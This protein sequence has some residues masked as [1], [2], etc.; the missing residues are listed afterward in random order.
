MASANWMKAT[1]QKAGAMKK[2]LGQQEREYGN[3]SN[4][5][6]D[7]TLSSLNYA[8]GCNDYNDALIRMRERTKSV[9]EVMPPLKVRKD[10]VVC[11]FLELPCPRVLTELG[12]SDEF[13][14]KAHKIY[15]EF[16]GAENTHGTFVHKDEVHEYT[17][18][19]GTVQVSC[20]HAHTLVSAYTEEKGINGKAFETRAKIKTLN[21]ALD[22]MCVREFGI[23]L[24]TGETPQRKSVETLKQESLAKD[25]LKE[26]NEKLNKCDDYIQKRIKQCEA[27]DEEVQYKKDILDNIEAE[28][29]QSVGLIEA[30]ENQNRFDD[31]I[32]EWSEEAEYENIDDKSKI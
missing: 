1:M 7:K 27:L 26:L 22:D 18:K 23:H 4:E 24:N 6:I 25:N 14:L 3:H 10:R 17:A 21:K 31:I 15:T 19:D 28:I 32:R 16:F 13:F 8:I 29:F 5:H 20:E 30:Q 9:D 11:C 12:M 2:H